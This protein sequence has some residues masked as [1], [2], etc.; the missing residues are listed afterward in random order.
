MLIPCNDNLRPCSLEKISHDQRIEDLKASL[1]AAYML[2]GIANRK[3]Y[4]TIKKYYDRRA[5]HREFKPGDFAMKV[6]RSRKFHRF[7]AGPYRITARKSD[8]NYEISGQDDKK[9][10][11]HVNR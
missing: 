7:W 5:K 10:I 6:R 9:Q 11:V 1:R 2:V 4:Q 8:L 3:S